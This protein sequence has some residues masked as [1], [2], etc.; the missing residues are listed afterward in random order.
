MGMCQLVSIL[1][2]A[3]KL[4]RVDGDIRAAVLPLLFASVIGQRGSADFRDTSE[5]TCTL[6]TGMMI[7]G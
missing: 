6:S 2:E 7:M 4:S 3:E 1:V 5:N